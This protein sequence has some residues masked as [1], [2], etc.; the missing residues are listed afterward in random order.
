[1][2]RDWFAD[3]P[4]RES[5]EGNV[6]TRRVDLADLKRTLKTNSTRAK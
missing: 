5:Q 2:G 4:W 3:H 1:M 6:S